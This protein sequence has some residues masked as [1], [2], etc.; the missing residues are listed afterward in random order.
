VTT[1]DDYAVN[2]LNEAI[3]E[4]L[5]LLCDGKPKRVGGVRAL[6]GELE[7]LTSLRDGL[8]AASVVPE[9][10]R[11]TRLLRRLRMAVPKRREG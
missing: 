4:R 5:E 6:Q 11:L 10:T 8:L 7:R 1:N 9:P 2:V 3:K